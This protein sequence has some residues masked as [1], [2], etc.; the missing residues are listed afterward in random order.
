MDRVAHLLCAVVALALVLCAPAD[1]VPPG[2]VSGTAAS[3]CDFRAIASAHPD[4][5]LR[6][7]DHLAGRLCAPFFLPRDYAAARDVMDTNPEAYA[8]YYYVNAR[9]RHFDARLAHA[10]AEGIDQVVILGAGFDSRAYRF[11]PRHPTLRFI[12][13]DLPATQAAKRQ[14]VTRVL[15]SLPAYVRYAPIDFDSE[16]LDQVLAN[17]GY[18]PKRRTLFILEGVTMYVGATG[19]DT[20]FAFIARHSAPGSRIVFDYLWRRVVDGDFAGLYGA[21]SSARGVAR[22]GEPYV[23]GWSPQAVEAFVT[24]HGLRV[25]DHLGSADMTR[26]YLT[27]SDGL[28]D[29]RIPE[30]YG[31]VDAG[32]P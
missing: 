16:S 22:V 20:T 17:A 7:P 26:R 23:T 10:A 5:A 31:I 3:T 29:G 12:E 24:G 15:G 19:N 2:A 14:A 30:W 9:T 21:S 4:P 32:V 1:A 11:A 6:N 8:G 28:P 13:V 27:G 18:D 25:L